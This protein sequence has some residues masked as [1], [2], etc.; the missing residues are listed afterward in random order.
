M[1]G[2]RLCPGSLVLPSPG[3]DLTLLSPQAAFGMETSMLLGAQ[4]PLSGKVKLIL[5]GITASRNTLAKVL[6]PHPPGDQPLR[7]LLP[8]AGAP[9]PE[10]VFFGSRGSG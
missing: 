5:E 10:V 1:N 8:F 2:A 3:G 9:P 4:K 7:L 6:P